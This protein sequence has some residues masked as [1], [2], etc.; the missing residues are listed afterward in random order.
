M[1][2]PMN[3]KVSCSDG[4]CGQSTYLVLKPTNEEITHVVV[5]TGAGLDS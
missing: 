1:D 4:P 3:T 5:G 2:I